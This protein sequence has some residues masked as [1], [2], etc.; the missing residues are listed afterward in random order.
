MKIPSIFKV[1]GALYLIKSYCKCNPTC[2]KCIFNK[3]HIGCQFRYKS[4]RE[5][6]IN[7]EGI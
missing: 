3:K 2:N 5:W 7:K 1:M 4:P 6:N